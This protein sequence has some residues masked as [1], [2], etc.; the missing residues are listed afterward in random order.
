MTST[1]TKTV[2]GTKLAIA[3]LA[4]LAAGSAAFVMMPTSQNTASYKWG[5]CT[6]PDSFVDGNPTS[7]SFIA[8]QLFAQSETN[9]NTGTKGDYC[10]TSPTTG[11]T[12][13]MEGICRNGTFGVWQKN[14]AELNATKPGS[15]FKC[16]EGACVNYGNYESDSTYGYGGSRQPPLPHKTQR[17]LV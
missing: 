13:L 4:M 10:Y 14:C 15:N 8:Q 3:T 5:G 1:A 9:Y 11:K 6:D 7:N 2:S 17:T 12:I 16:L